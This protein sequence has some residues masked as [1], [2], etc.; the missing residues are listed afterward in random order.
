M[1][2]Y[3][4]NNWDMICYFQNHYR[5]YFDSSDIFDKLKNGEFS[6]LDI[7]NLFRFRVFLDSTI[8]MFNK[9]KLE[10]EYFKKNFQYID[11]A[12]AV[13]KFDIVGYYKYIRKVIKESPKN[14][15]FENINFIDDNF[16]D[17]PIAIFAN[18]DNENTES[19]DYI[20]AEPI[21]AKFFDQV[22]RLRNSFAHMQYGCFVQ[23]EIGYMYYYGIYNKD[24]GIKR[25][26][27]I[28]FERIIHEFV[29]RF[30]SNQATYGIPYK[31]SF[32]CHFDSNRNYL[33]DLFFYEIKYKF[34]ADIKYDVS[35]KQHPMIE[36]IKHQYTFETIFDFLDKDSNFIIKSEKV[37]CS[38]LTLIE[39][40]KVDSDIL[41][42]EAIDWFLK[43]L[44]D[45]E[46]EF[47]NFILHLRIVVDTIIEYNSRLKTGI[48][49]KEFEKFQSDC[50]K[51]IDEL[52]EDE[53]DVVAFNNL[54]S[55]LKL[56]DIMIRAEDD[57]LEPLSTKFINSSKFQYNPKD[58]VDWINEYYQSNDV[59]DDDKVELPRKFILTKIRNAVAHGNI[60]LA[61]DNIGI[62][63]NFSEKFNNRCVDIS[64]NI[65]DFEEMCKKIQL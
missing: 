33:E 10:K 30:Y 19:D 2:G 6:S 12:N 17:N 46:T 56:Y 49:T 57:D 50:K 43:L 7:G 31:H 48:P 8:M 18:L 39:S 64:V 62:S 58:L 9:E 5:G 40:F 65:N 59:K 42:K 54:F 36:Y 35:K 22:S 14:T 37:E 51:R 29:E 28:A 47:S 24:K 3:T 13:F 1:V 52:K 44:F 34:D 55:V 15:I 45:F 20:I 11:F 4:Q 27:G 63:I 53:N 23:D 21:V 61:L 25:N 16:K 26:C 41:K 60:K 38:I 32:F